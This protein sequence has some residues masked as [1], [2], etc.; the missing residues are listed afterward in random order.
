MRF[1]Q[2]G[3]YPILSYHIKL[4]REEFCDAGID[5]AIHRHTGIIVRH[6]SCSAIVEQ[7]RNDE[8]K[9]TLGGKMQSRIAICIGCIDAAT[10]FDQSFDDGQLSENACLVQGRDALAIGLRD[11]RPGLN[12]GNDNIQNTTIK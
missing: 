9:S 2:K 4:L 8:R 11:I 1:R 7:E 10:R 12:E 6:G 5:G 3:I